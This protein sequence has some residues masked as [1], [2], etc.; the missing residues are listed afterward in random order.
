MADLARFILVLL[1]LT[2]LIFIQGTRFLSFEG[3]NPN[4]ILIFFSGLIMA[5]HFRDRIKFTFLLALLAFSLLVSSFISGFWLIIWSILLILVILIYFFRDFFTGHPFPD[6]LLVLGLGTAVFYG[7]LN[8]ITGSVF[9]GGIVL[10][11]IA[12]NFILGGIF[13]LCL[14]LLKK[15]AQSR[16]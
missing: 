10:R 13:W 8:I 11:E 7:L 9:P 5:P 2:I 4:L 3:I 15:H 12:Y 6:F 14:Y 16:P 1:V